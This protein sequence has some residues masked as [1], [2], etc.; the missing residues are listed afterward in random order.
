MIL[1]DTA[2]SGKSNTAYLTSK[3]HS[4]YILHILPSKNK[5]EVTVALISTNDRKTFLFYYSYMT[6]KSLILNFCCSINIISSIAKEKKFLQFGNVFE[7]MY[8]MDQSW[9]VFMGYLFKD[10]TTTFSVSYLQYSK[11]SLINSIASSL[12]LLELA[13]VYIWYFASFL[14]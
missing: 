10:V 14:A 8:I 3:C 7:C 11:P 1:K 4:A 6:G 13:K 2:Y 5:I 9:C 12:N